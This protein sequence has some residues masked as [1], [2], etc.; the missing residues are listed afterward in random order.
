MCDVA[1]VSGPANVVTHRRR[2]ELI[3][4]LFNV[5]ARHEG[6]A[7]VETGRHALTRF[8]ERNRLDAIVC[9]HSFLGQGFIETIA[10]HDRPPIVACFDEIPMMHVLPLPIVCG[11][12]DIPLLAETAVN[13]LLPQLKREPSKIQPV[14]LPARVVTN[15]A[16]QMRQSAAT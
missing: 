6:A 8:A 14:T 11:M 1:L 15:R 9:T 7:T 16:F 10:Q 2:A 13:L 5:V 12:Q 4:R 3:A